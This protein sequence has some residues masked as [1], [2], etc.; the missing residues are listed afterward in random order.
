MPVTTFHVFTSDGRQ[1]TFD[2]N[3]EGFIVR[4]QQAL[5]EPRGVWPHAYTEAGRR[6]VGG[7]TIVNPVGRAIH[8][9]P[10]CITAVEV[11]MSEDG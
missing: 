8:F 5:N 10:H 9:N 3:A 1:R 11:E 2:D 7:I 6:I 4:W